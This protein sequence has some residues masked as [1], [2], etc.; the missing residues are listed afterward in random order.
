MSTFLDDRK[1]VT[2]NVNM[3]DDVVKILEEHCEKNQISFD[4]FAITELCKLMIE[5]KDL[6]VQSL[7][8]EI[9]RLKEQNKGLK[10]F[11]VLN[12]LNIPEKLI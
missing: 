4:V 7:K 11:C 10:S 12:R 8:K 1:Y 5:D 2:I 3:E 6:E 9:K